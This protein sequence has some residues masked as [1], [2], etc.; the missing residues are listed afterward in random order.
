MT[1][2]QI[3]EA[4]KIIEA[5]TPGPWSAFKKHKYHE[6]PVILAGSP[7]VKNGI[8]VCACSGGD[9]GMDDANFIAVARTLLPQALDEIERLQHALNNLNADADHSI[10]L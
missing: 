6:T 10:I 8:Y 5:A 3:A 4:R 9:D 2:E 7:R 1:P